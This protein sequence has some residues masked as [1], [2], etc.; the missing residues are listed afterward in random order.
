MRV[1]SGGL[2]CKEETRGSCEN[3]HQARCCNARKVCR[4]R[5]KLK[6]CANE[7]SFLSVAGQTSSNRTHHLKSWGGERMVGGSTQGCRPKDRAQMGRPKRRAL[8]SSSDSS[9]LCFIVQA[10]SSCDSLFTFVR[11]PFSRSLLLVKDL[12]DGLKS[13]RERAF[14]RGSI[15]CS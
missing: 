8:R 5:C 3:T 13:S 6:Y 15:V 11:S 9:S 14:C 2:V 4:L 12:N 7:G 1:S 10:T